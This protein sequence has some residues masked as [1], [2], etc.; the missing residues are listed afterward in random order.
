LEAVE[1]GEE[2][3]IAEIL[4]K[5]AGRF[6]RR[7]L[8]VLVSDLYDEP[9]QV[10]RALHHFRH[11]KHEVIVFHVFDRAE[12]EFPFRDVTAFYDLETGERLQ[13]DPAYVRDDYREQVEGFIETYR[14]ACTESRIDYVMTDT[15][16]PYDFMLS[17][18][19]AKR[20]AT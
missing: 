18:Y 13:I 4:H 7:C 3:D 2:T 15:S 19:L 14:R 20:N 5:L 6:K 10:L 12:I 17:R 8:I 9:E 11:R 16:V 1:P